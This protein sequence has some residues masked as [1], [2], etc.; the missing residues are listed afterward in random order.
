[1]RV[2]VTGKAVQLAISLAERAA[3]RTNIELITL[4]RPELDLEQPETIGQNIQACRPDIVV[5][6]AAF[7]SVD[8]AESQPERA[9]AVNR[10]GAGAV[11]RAAQHAG[12]P[13]VH[14]STD[15]VF[16]GEKLQPYIEAD[17]T[18]PLNV[19]GLSKLQGEQSVLAAHPDAL[20]LRTSWVFSPFRSNFLK[21]MLKLGSERSVLR[22]VNDQLGSPTS[23]LDLA[24]AI[25]DIAPLLSNAPGGVYHL[26]GQGSTSWHGFASYIFAESRKYGGPSPVV[27]AIDSSEYPT[28]ALRP[29]DA[30]LD[31]SAFAKRFGIKLRPWEDATAEIV[32]R[33]V[34]ESSSAT[35]F[36]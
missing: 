17:E 1:M 20:I 8:M 25:L 32:A 12:V 19:Y 29:K 14:I 16:S 36:S 26:S 2:L 33:R 7:T 3:G 18:G 34:R 11:A 31:C 28:P 35:S 24:D 13:F 5:N 15:Y 21:T 6:A 30:R 4:G 10:N 22:V 27:E 9:F 23:S